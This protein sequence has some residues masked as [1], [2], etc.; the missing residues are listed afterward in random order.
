MNQK[1]RKIAIV[2]NSIDPNLYD[3]IE[4][5]SS[6]LESGWDSFR[7]P[8]G[9]L[10]DLENGG[11]SHIILT[12]SEA[13][14]LE[15]ERWAENEIK[16]AQKAV[17]KNVALLASCYGHQLLAMALAG[18]KHVQR[19]AEPEAGWISL[20]IRDENG[21]LDNNE[22][23]YSFTLHFDEV[24]D[25]GEEFTVFA[26]TDNCSIQAFQWKDKSVWGLQIHPEITIPQGQQ[27][28]RNL[29]SKDYPTT[30]VYKKALDSKPQ[31]SGHIRKII[32]NFL[33][34]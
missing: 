26:S 34:A 25:L 33:S 10:P 7:A 28:L 1:D 23:I 32:D 20:K 29:I 6:F 11:Y 27:L 4:H 12:G 22:E 9:E 14:I 16:F 30:P 5:W 18:L 24:I 31:D 19:C 8:D 3:P 21:L 13:S 15:R 2:D 17:E